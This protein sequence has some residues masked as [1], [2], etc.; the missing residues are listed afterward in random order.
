VRGP[1]YLDADRV[2]VTSLST[3]GSRAEVLTLATGG[4]RPVSPKGETADA[5]GAVAGG[6]WVVYATEKAVWAVPA[7]G[8]KRVRLAGLAKGAI[9]VAV[10][11]AGTQAIVAERNG[12]VV[13]LR[14]I[15]L[16][17]LPVRE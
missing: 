13:Q 10:D 15:S 7:G 12:D 8:G 4:R 3:K 16:R 11:S 5:L 2:L 1:T 9:A 6:S 14:A 17:G